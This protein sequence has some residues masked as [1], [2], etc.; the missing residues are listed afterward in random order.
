MKI[1]YEL[2]VSMRYSMHIVKVLR[3]SPHM[4]ELKSMTIEKIFSA[5]H[6]KKALA[7]AKRYIKQ[8]IK[9]GGK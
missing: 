9:E 7:D 4:G 5:T 2:D 1:T 3:V 6:K 8:L